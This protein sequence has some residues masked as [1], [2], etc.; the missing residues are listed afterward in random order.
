MYIVSSKM[1]EKLNGQIANTVFQITSEPQTIAVS[2]NKK[3]LTHEL[4]QESKL[5]SVSILAKYAPLKF[6]GRFGFRSGR[7]FSKFENIDYKYG[8]TNVPIVLENS[9]GYVESKVI[10][11]LDAG[12][13]TLFIADVIDL[14]IILDEEPMIYEYYLNVKRGKV[15]ET[16][17]TYIKKDQ[18]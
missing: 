18:K 16:A 14:Q 17:P 10:E 2:I 4:I 15:P 9:I 1:G 5:F 3:N 8:I 6:I 13:H 11:T 7:D 12:T